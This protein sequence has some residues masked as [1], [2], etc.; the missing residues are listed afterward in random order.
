MTTSQAERGQRHRAKLAS[1]KVRAI[2]YKVRTQRY[3]AA[4]LCKCGQAPADPGY[5]TC[6]R[7]REA[8]NAYHRK[9]YRRLAPAKRA[10]NLCHERT[11]ENYRVPGFKRCDY[12]LEVRAET[13]SRRRLAHKAAGLCIQCYEPVEVGGYTCAK[14][15]AM[16]RV[17]EQRR[18][19]R[20][21]QK[22]SA[23]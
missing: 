20:L 1:L 13:Q 18:Q 10:F 16:Q 21:K 11:C 3:A 12:H 23:A 17:Y 15:A 8:K 19:D 4:G 9:Q 2:G 5:K 14:H 22:R 6:S 7:C